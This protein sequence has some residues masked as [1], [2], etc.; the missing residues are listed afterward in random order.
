MAIRIDEISDRVP[1]IHGGRPEFPE[2]LNLVHPSIP[3]QALLMEDF[4]SIL[5]GGILT[6]GSHV[7]ELERRAAEYLGVRH[8]IA[9]A[10]CTAGL[11]L[12][13]KA[14]DLTG[15]VIAPS[16]TFSATTHAVVW[17]GL[18]PVYA[19]IDPRSLTLAPEAVKPLVGVRTSA[20]VATHIYGTPCDVE[21]L[22]QIAD[23]NGI[24]L[25]FDAAHGFGSRRGERAV[26][27]FGDAEVFSL[28]PTKVMIAGEG[29][30]IATNDDILAERL[31]IGRDYGNPGDYDCLFIGLNARMSEFHAAIAL[32]SLADLDERILRRNELVG[33]YRE[34]LKGIPGIGFP[35]VGE[36]NW[37]TFKDFTIFVDE[38]QFG[39]GPDQLKD[40]LDAEGIDTRRYYSPA[41]HKMKAYESVRAGSGPLP[42]T[43]WAA[44]TVLTLPLWTEMI[45][46]EI[47]RV[48]GAI[49]R[50][51]AHSPTSR[52]LSEKSTSEGS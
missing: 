25:F 32:G 43:E 17:N 15:D 35:E 39:M 52:I 33:I 21:S 14:A 3:D 30:I 38:S 10:S 22:Q 23:D 1:A 5:D 26:G 20:I 6:N 9:V 18:R 13:F 7:K 2:R 11:M 28:S 24:K 29:G 48:A 37:S 12:L 16:F 40:A 49:A 42:V 50:L 45:G 31:R 19:D 27:S 36:G 44:D 34:A 47:G 8:C 4:K 41:V 46:S 51:A